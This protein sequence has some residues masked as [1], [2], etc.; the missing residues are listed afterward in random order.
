M[1][2]YLLQ[3]AL[4]YAQSLHCFTFSWVFYEVV[5]G[6]ISPAVDLIESGA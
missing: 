2:M 3:P 1:S 6:E 4:G 5:K